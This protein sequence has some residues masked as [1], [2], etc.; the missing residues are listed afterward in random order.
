M[1]KGGDKFMNWQ[2]ASG[3][4]VF[5]GSDAIKSIYRQTLTAKNLDIVCL[6]ENYAK[7]IGSFFDREY[8]PKLFN[9]R[10]VT[11]EILPDTNTNREDAKKKDGVKNAVR[12]LKTDKPSESDFMI[13]EETVIL[14]SYNPESPFAVVISDKD[15]V[16][17]LKNQFEA[18]WRCLSA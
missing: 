16:S 4:Q 9:S 2:N 18:L 7:V 8:A 1:P 10:T 3:A 12:F 6:S 17:N 13:Y 15:I 14:I 11:R 5:F